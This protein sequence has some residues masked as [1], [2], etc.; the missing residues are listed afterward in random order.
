MGMKIANL[1]YMFGLVQLAL[2]VDSEQRTAKLQGLPHVSKK[3]LAKK[4]YT[5]TTKRTTFQDRLKFGQRFLLL[6]GAGTLSMLVIIAALDLRVFITRRCHEADITCLATAIREVHHR[7]WLPLVKRLMVPIHYVRHSSGYIQ[8]LK[9]KY[10]M[11]LKAEEPPKII[12]FGFQDHLISDQIFDDIQ[13][14]LIKPAKRKVKTPS[15]GQP[16]SDFTGLPDRSPAW[17]FSPTPP[18]WK[19]P[20]DPEDIGLPPPVTIKTPLKLGKSACPVKKKNRNE[21]TEQQRSFAD[22]APIAT[23]REDLQSKLNAMHKG[24]TCRKNKYVEIKSN[25]LDDKALFIRDANGKLLSLLFKIPEE[26]RAGLQS[27]IDHINTV[28]LGEWKD[29]DSRRSAFKYLSLHYSW[30]ARF[31]EKGHTAPKDVHPDK[32]K[33]V[34]VK[35][36]NL[37]G[38]VPHQSS[39]L[40]EEPEEYAALANAFT[41]FFEILKVAVAYYLPDD[42]K[43][44]SIYVDELPLGATSPCHPFGGFVINISSCTWGHRDKDKN[45]CLIASMGEHTGGQLC[46]HEAGLK[47]D[48]RLGDVLIFPSCDL[49]HFNCHFR[50]R[51]ATIVLHTDR[52]ANSWTGDA[53]G[54][55]AYVVNHRR[56]DENEGKGEDEDEGEDEGEVDED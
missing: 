21:W 7:K 13:T 54:W 32:C 6:C 41:N 37:T 15:T 11:P 16:P 44:L 24:G 39:E 35:H 51:R 14:N 48:L 5:S 43:E 1:E 25:I 18:L 52:E 8:T 22:N 45:M 33:K 42:T 47:F 3:D 34:G 9:L 10:K 17:E 12:E 19:V 36:V 30:Y 56:H 29:D 46:L 49:T 31:A 50:G 26:Y 2:N 4:Y 28:L 40:L 53:H 27:A 38:R 55:N 23:S 20:S